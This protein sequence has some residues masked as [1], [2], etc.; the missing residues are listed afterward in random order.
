[1]ARK[2]AEPRQ[3]IAY[4]YSRVSHRNSRNKGDSIAAQKERIKAY[5][6]VNLSENGT[7]WGGNYDDDVAISAFRTAFH[8]RPAGKE[9]MEKLQSGDHLVI[10]KVDRLFRSMSDYANTIE[11]LNKL[12]VTVHIIS[13]LGQTIRYDTGAGKFM[14]SMLVAF[15]EL[16]SSL[17]SERIREALAYKRANRISGSWVPHGCKLKYSQDPDG[18]TVRKLTWST[19]DRAIMGEI[20][21]LRDDVRLPWKKCYDKIEEFAAEKEGRPKRNAKQQFQDRQKRWPR[22]Y[23]Y[24]TAYRLLN[25]R[26]PSQI[27]VKAELMRAAAEHRENRERKK[28]LGGKKTSLSNK[29]YGPPKAIT[30]LLQ[31][32]N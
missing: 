8:A 5:Y 23:A 2:K 25:I 22:M 31:K 15:A 11:R 29:D 17:K 12:G 32:F 18:N 27:P 3:P 6:D 21:R 28:K 16:E 13:F 20:V 30:E 7:A 10:D 9:L 4:G 14:L 1:M 19:V 24:E 26:D